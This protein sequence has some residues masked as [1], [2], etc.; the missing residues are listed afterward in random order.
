MAT[1][2]NCCHVKAAILKVFPDISVCLD[3]WHFMMRYMICIAG[4]IK[5]PVRPAVARDIVDAVLK[6]PA[7]GHTPAVYWNQAEQERRLVEAYNKWEA[8]GNVW[9][10]A[11]VKAHAE[12]LSHVKKGCLARPRNDVRSDGSRIESSHKGWNGLQ[13]SHASGLESLTAL[14]HDFVLRRN[15]R[16]EM[17]TGV[18]ASAFVR[19]TYGSHHVRLVD[20]I[21][22]LWNDILG[23]MQRS[24]RALPADIKPLPALEP[25][26]S[27]E[28]FGLSTMGLTTAAHH[29]LITLKEEPTDDNLLDLSSQDLL[30]AQQIL[31]DIGIDP[32][33][34]YQLPQHAAATPIAQVPADVQP[35]APSSSTELIL[36]AAGSATS[37]PSLSQSASTFLSP[38][39]DPSTSSL[40]T[41]LE[42]LSVKQPQA[43][44][45]FDI[46]CIDVDALDGYT[47]PL[48]VASPSARE[49]ESQDTVKAEEASAPSTSRSAKG[50]GRKRRAV[51]ESD[52]ILAPDIN[53]EDH[54]SSHRIG[55][56]S[57][58][59][60]AVPTQPTSIEDAPSPKKKIRITVAGMPKT[61]FGRRTF[62]AAQT[63]L[64]SDVDATQSDSIRQRALGTPTPD[65]RPSLQAGRIE[66]FFATPQA[67]SSFKQPPIIHSS[68]PSPT[69][70]GLTRSQRLFSVATGVDPRSLS[71]PRNA[72]AEEYFLFMRLRKEQQWASF[73]MTPFDWVCAAS[74]YN[75][76]LQKLN[77]E[78]GRALVMKTP[79]A[80]MEK[81]GELEPDILG[82]IATDNYSSRNHKDSPFWREHCHAVPLGKTQGGSK[83]N[84]QSKKL[85]KNHTCARCKTIKYPGPEGS[86]LNH[87]KLYCSD[88]VRQ[89]AQKVKTLIGSQPVDVLEEPPPFPQ[90]SEVFTNGTHFHP[91]RFISA[92]QELY[93]R[94]IA[95]H[96]PGG[97][98]AMQD[99]AFASLLRERTQ[100]VPATEEQQSMVLFKLYSSLQMGSCPPEII[101]ERSGERY[102]RID[103]LSDPPVAEPGNS[104]GSGV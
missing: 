32:A 57:L 102:L 10:A 68:L 54:R 63:R 90:P 4:G 67:S 26:N 49:L 44:K 40:A 21:A 79:R 86:D 42:L 94:V 20:A 28:T 53:T 48:S 16:V 14:C 19:S 29:A 85:R 36:P 15:L 99:L 91:I 74:L 55:Q 82:R 12:Q 51:D 18:D 69:I 75:T 66:R 43:A 83:V 77:R 39:R 101:I 71:F 13:R 80:L 103:Y 47:S 87:K 2:D 58:D 34:M 76:E 62:G 64:N 72:D 89:A 96:S 37:S 56:P 22:R 45:S 73:R 84:G 52:G 5:N 24:G 9:S 41:A 27:G 23:D 50:L 46:E 92:V 100:V 1:V 95:A 33:L 3:V 81:L 11:A 97:A 104:E 7:N 31:S 30:N 65:G 78:R 88:G 59:D 38:P 93:E 60:T 25:V 35:S 6:S 17:A 8:K 61:S 70:S 98:S